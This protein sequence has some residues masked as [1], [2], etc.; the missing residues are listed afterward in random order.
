ME[1]LEKLELTADAGIVT[2]VYAA[3][4]SYAVEVSPNGFGGA[5][6][7]MVGITDGKVTGISIISHAETPGLGAVA[8]ANTDKGTAFRDQFQGLINGITIGD[9]EN[10]IDALTGAT[11][12]S[13]AIVDGVNAALEYVAKLG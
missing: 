7:M 9:G 10:Q 13:Q 12:T 1:G 6:S 3:N 11:I 4:N 8:S 2:G 5:I